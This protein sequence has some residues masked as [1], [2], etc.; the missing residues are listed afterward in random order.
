MLVRKTEG[1][2]PPRGIKKPPAGCRP[3][4]GWMSRTAHR[5]NI[6]IIARKNP[7]DKGVDL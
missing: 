5:E 4:Q 6:A 3:R 1:G 7:V 2:H